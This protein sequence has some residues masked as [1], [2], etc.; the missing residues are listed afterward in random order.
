[1]RA[2]AHPAGVGMA[3]EIRRRLGDGDQEIVRLVHA[4]CRAG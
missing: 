3:E 4:Q 2:P 1:M